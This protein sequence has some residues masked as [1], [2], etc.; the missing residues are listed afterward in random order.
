MRNST[1]GHNGKIYQILHCNV[2]NQNIHNQ[3]EIFLLN[4][5]SMFD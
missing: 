2:K 3:I 4:L 1:N 5:N